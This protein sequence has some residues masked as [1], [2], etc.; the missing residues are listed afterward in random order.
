MNGPALHRGALKTPPSDHIR[1]A[2]VVILAIAW[3]PLWSAAQTVRGTVL[4][5]TEA[6]A[7]FHALLTLTESTSAATLSRIVSTGEPFRV[8]LPSRGTWRVRAEL[9]GYGT[10]DTVVVVR[11]G[12][13]VELTLLLSPDPLMVDG[14]TVEV[15]GSE[16]P[17]VHDPEKL[18]SLWSEARKVLV[19]ATTDSVETARFQLKVTGGQAHYRTDLAREETPFVTLTVDTVWSIGSKPVEVPEAR[20]LLEDGFILPKA[21]S[22]DL[23]RYQYFAPDAEVILSDL[24]LS[25]HCFSRLPLDEAGNF[26]GL[27][28]EPRKNS[29]LDYDVAGT[30]R[31]PRRDTL[32]PYIEFHWTEH[33]RSSAV[34]AIT[35]GVNQPFPLESIRAVDFEEAT[36]GRIDFANVPNFGWIAYRWQLRTPVVNRITR[37]VMCREDRSCLRSYLFMFY[38]RKWTAEVIRVQVDESR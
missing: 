15:D 28:F 6:G 25:S 13:D 12:G 38:T 2:M 34:R 1:R 22:E 11:S 24:F 21:E 37:S 17:A 10:V 14:L 29:P 19:S 7:S 8:L 32:T 26:D 9:L 33:P 27:R 30:I 16:C 20:V 4:A 5:P 18:L 35:S 23:Y 3:S 31:L 36:G